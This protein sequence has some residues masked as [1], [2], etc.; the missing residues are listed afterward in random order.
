M[1]V[2]GGCIGTAQRWRWKSLRLLLKW[3]VMCAPL[4]VQAQSAQPP[5]PAARRSVDAPTIVLKESL[6]CRGCKVVAR[7]VAV[8]TDS[9]FDISFEFSLVVGQDARGRLLVTGRKAIGVFDS[10]GRFIKSLTRY[11]SGP[12]EFRQ[13]FQFVVGPGDSLFVSDIALSRVSVFDPTFTTLARTVSVPRL[14][15]FLPRADGQLTLG[16]YVATKEGAGQ[17]LH[18]VS[19]SGGVVRSFGTDSAIV[20]HD[21]RRT[22]ARS[23]VSRANGDVLAA[24][25]DRYRLSVWG[26]DSGLRRVFERHAI[27]FPGTGPEARVDHFARTAS[28]PQ[29]YAI[30]STR[31]PN[32]LLVNIVMPRKDYKPDPRLQ[33]SRGEVGIK[34]NKPIGL[35]VN[36]YFDTIIEFLDLEQ[37][38]VLASS[39][40]RGIYGPISHSPLHWRIQERPD[41]NLELAI[42]RFELVRSATSPQ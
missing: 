9:L 11:G 21:P 27:W 36:D 32:I 30:A 22:L 12:G 37:G 31:D 39:R 10:A 17:P 15:E 23:L 26:N 16:G 3:V 28:P 29:L 25:R 35:Y 1:P 5:T 19:R 18:V 24:E 4:V 34:P 33:G 2:S 7:S 6:T 13:P 8:I 14:T 41:G 38:T 40:L 20:G 42:V